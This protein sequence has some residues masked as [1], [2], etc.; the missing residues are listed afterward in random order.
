MSQNSMTY[1]QRIAIFLPDT[2]H[3]SRWVTNQL[4]SHSRP[5]IPAPVLL[6]RDRPDRRAQTQTL[7]DTPALFDK[8]STTAYPLAQCPE[9]QCPSCDTCS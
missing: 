3:A 7:K 6:G 2:R 5:V 8:L 1:L 4:K 9:D